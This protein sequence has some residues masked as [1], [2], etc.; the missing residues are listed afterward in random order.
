MCLR[1]ATELGKGPEN[2]C[3]EEQLR[4]VM[5]FREGKYSGSERTYNYL[6][7]GI[8]LSVCS[9]ISQM[10]EQKEIVLNCTRGRLDNKSHSLQC[11]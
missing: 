3:C 8:S 4:Q 7:G 5:L 6:K 2:V 9:A 11:G 10:K 1:K